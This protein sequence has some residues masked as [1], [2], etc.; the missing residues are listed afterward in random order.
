M[1]IG[2]AVAAFTPSF[3]IHSPHD[4]TTKHNVILGELR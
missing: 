1:H 3:F 4:L 2:H